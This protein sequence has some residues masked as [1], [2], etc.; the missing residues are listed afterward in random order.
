M[1]LSFAIQDK[2]NR[3]E[4]KKPWLNLNAPYRLSRSQASYDQIE[5]P[6]ERCLF[7]KKQNKTQEKIDGNSRCKKENVVLAG[8][9]R[10][11]K[12]LLV[13]NSQQERSRICYC[14]LNS[15]KIIL[16]SEGSRRMKD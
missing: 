2:V 12:T 13:K 10:T 16:E 5:N 4:Q 9:K 7:K 1:L 3:T 6:N 14:G 11:Q 8:R 15:R